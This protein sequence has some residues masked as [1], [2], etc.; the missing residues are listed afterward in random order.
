MA[1]TCLYGL[2]GQPSIQNLVHWQVHDIVQGF[3]TGQLPATR[4][5][6]AAF[7][8]WSLINM[9]MMKKIKKITYKYTFT[10]SCNDY[11]STLAKKDF[12]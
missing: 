7:S 2:H 1:V 6:G 11:T 4:S 10:C 3:E 12:E 9:M 8:C 5:Y